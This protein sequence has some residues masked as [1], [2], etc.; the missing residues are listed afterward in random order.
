[1]AENIK[2]NAPEEP[3]LLEKKPFKFA[4]TNAKNQRIT[5]FQTNYDYEVLV[6]TKNSRENGT[7]PIKVTVEHY[8]KCK[9]RDEMEIAKKIP[10]P[11][12]QL[13][14]VG[15]KRKIQTVVPETP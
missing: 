7:A 11:S 8:L 4:V 9:K 15:W 2:I 1:M 12:K 13:K 14:E 10:I 6:T 5:M 3:E